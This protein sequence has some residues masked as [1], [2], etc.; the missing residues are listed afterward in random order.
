MGLT[1][2]SS[3]YVEIFGQKL[4]MMFEHRISYVPQRESVRLGFS[5]QLLWIVSLLHG[6][7]IVPEKS[8][9]ARISKADKACYK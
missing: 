7:N 9:P 6:A 2:L 4:E 5:C 8:I 3:G 1:Q